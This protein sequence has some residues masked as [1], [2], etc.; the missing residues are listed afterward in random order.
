[1]LGSVKERFSQNLFIHSLIHSFIQ[2]S[3]PS[4]APNIT[5]SGTVLGM[6]VS[7][8]LTFTLAEERQNTVK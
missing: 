1:M 6:A 8:E 2:Q 5:V 4:D 7:N 3:F